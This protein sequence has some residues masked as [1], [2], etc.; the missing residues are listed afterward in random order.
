MSVTSDSDITGIPSTGSLSPLTTKGDLYTYSTTNA[1]LPVG[2]DGQA[3]LADSSTATGLK[4]AAAGISGSGT[5]NRLVRWDG[6]SAVQDSGVTLSDTDQFTWAPSNATGVS[7]AT[8]LSGTTGNFWTTTGT[9]GGTYTWYHEITNPNNNAICN[10]I[11]FGGT[12]VTNR[13]VIASQFDTNVNNTGYDLDHYN[14]LRGSYGVYSSATNGNTSGLSC[15]Y[16]GY[17]LSGKGNIGGSFLAATALNVANNRTWGVRAHAVTANSAKA[18]GGHFSIGSTEALMSTDPGESA[19]LVATNTTGTDPIQR[20]YDNTTEVARLRD[21]GR[22]TVGDPSEAVSFFVNDATKFMANGTMTV[23][24]SGASDII[25]IGATTAFNVNPS[26]D[27]NT[28][29]GVGVYAG[30]GFNLTLVG[31]SKFNGGIAVAGYPNPISAIGA[32]GQVN[33][34]TDDTVDGC[35]GLLCS[36]GPQGNGA[37]VD[38]YVGGAFACNTAVDLGSTGSLNRGTGGFFT[39]YTDLASDV[40][41]TTARSGWFKEP[42]VSGGGTATI[43]NKT[44]IYLEGTLSIVQTDSSDTGNIDAFVVSTSHHYMTGAAPVLRGIIPDT[45]NKVVIFDFANTATISNENATPTAARRITTGTGAD[46]TNVKSVCVIYNTTTSR[47][48]V[49]WWRV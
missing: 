31:S 13:Y 24:S 33:I 11:I 45:N 35:I 34:Q 16:Y 28:G 10:R 48:R 20:W 23:V 4:W 22:L 21:G 37:T 41:I 47:W 44:A 1:R 8:T 26:A 2:I 12:S 14:S 25:Q 19:A 9:Q 17:A 15:A 36:G 29:L 42:Y 18:V 3:L 43:T 39:V 32:F 27:T 6:T 49:Q 38:D 7:W 30:Q 46:L 5:D 40:S